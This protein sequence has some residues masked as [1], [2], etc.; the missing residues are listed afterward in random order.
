[1]TPAEIQARVH[2]GVP[3][4][5]LFGIEVV[6]AGEGVAV[7]RLPPAPLLLRPGN[8]LSGPAI[9][10][11]C[12]V[13]IWAAFLTAT[14]GDDNARTQHLAVTFLKPAGPGPLLAEARIVRR[15]ARVVY[16][17][18]WLR[19]EGAEAPC[20]HCTSTWVVVA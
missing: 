4:A 12:D 9:M 1:M 14:G 20:G 13:A 8:T 2:E 15:G 11:L 10:G 17:D 6:S 5:A 7:L 3:L 19:A 16:A 18:V